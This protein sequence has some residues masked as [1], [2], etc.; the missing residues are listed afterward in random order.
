M[1]P[2][3]RFVLALPF[4]TLAVLLSIPSCLCMYAAARIEGQN[5]V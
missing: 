3:W 5:P 4:L 2:T 1:N